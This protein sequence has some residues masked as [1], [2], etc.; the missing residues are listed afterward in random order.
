MIWEILVE[1]IPWAGMSAVEVFTTVV[2]N[3]ERLNTDGISLNVVQRLIINLFTNQP[4]HRPSSEK[5][6]K[7]IQR[8]PI[9]SVQCL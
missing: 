4:V 3:K 7:I 1:A 8:I 6:K 2:M 9:H 5:I